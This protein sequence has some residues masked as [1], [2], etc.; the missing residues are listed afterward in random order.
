MSIVTVAV[1][2][3]AAATA[4]IALSQQT[5]QA[6]VVKRVSNALDIQNQINGHVHSGLPTLNQQM[7]LVQEQ[8]DLLWTQ[9]HSTCSQMYI[10]MCVTLGRVVD[11]SH[12]V[13]RLSGYVQGPWV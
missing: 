8:L 13:W 1:S 2:A 6:D 10:S 7:V 11:A 4:G 5:R 12:E 3:V 9:Q